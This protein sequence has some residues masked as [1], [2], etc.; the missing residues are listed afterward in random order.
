MPIDQEKFLKAKR[1]ATDFDLDEGSGNVLVKAAT[2]TRA[3][4][5]ELATNAEALLGTD[6]SRVITPAALLAVISSLVAGG[7]DK[8]VVGAIG[9][10]STT[11]VLILELSDG[12]T[13]SVSMSAV[14]A[15]AVSSVPAATSSVAGVVELATQS[16]SLLGSDTTRAV[17]PAGLKST[18][19]ALKN[20]SVNNEF[21]LSC[22]TSG[23]A[24]AIV[25]TP[26]T[27][28]DFAAYAPFQSVV[29]IA[30]FN[31]TGAVTVNV[32]GRG[33]VPLLKK[34]LLPLV[35]GDLL[36]GSVFRIVFDG[37]NFQIGGGGTS[38]LSADVVLRTGAVM[39]GALA[40]STQ[41]TAVTATSTVLYSPSVHGQSPVFTM[42]GVSTVTFGPPVGI[43]VGT[44]YR[45]LL[46]AADT[47]LRTLVWDPAYYKFPGGVAAP[48]AGA[49]VVGATD[50]ITFVGGPGN[51]LLQVDVSLGVR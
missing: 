18:V 47:S 3:G 35:A 33:A 48:L 13:V 51:T 39:T 15:D 5:V 41:D 28:I 12:S 21:L 49:I 10:N 26:R 24:N 8:Y 1:F 23:T 46:R 2:T 17:T 43:A 22:V 42:S 11:N 32:A 9:Y 19:D 34:G 40:L 16:E 38:A 4:K 31:N 25:L 44:E 14:I 6:T 45:F 7:F 20:Q 27:G 50:I 29:F 30:N 37:T 36:A